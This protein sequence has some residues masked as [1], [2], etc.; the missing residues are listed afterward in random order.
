M[1]VGQD[2]NIKG[3]F[4]KI[5]NFNLRK[6]YIHQGIGGWGWGWV[7]IMVHEGKISA[8]GFQLFILSENVY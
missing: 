8:F 5:Q 3:G 2:S 7:G 4:Q 6:E 1:V